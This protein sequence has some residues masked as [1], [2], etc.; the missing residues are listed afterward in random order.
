MPLDTYRGIQGE[1]ASVRPSSHLLGVV[2]VQ[3]PAACEPTQYSPAYTRLHLLDMRLRE[4]RFA[5]PNSLPALRPR[6]EHPVD[7]TGVEMQV[8]VERRAETMHEA[9]R[10]QSCLLGTV[11]VTVQSPSSN[12]LSRNGRGSGRGVKKGG[13]TERLPVRGMCAQRL[14]DVPQEDVQHGRDRSAVL[15]QKVPQA[16]GQRQHPMA[17]RKRRKD[18]IDQMR[19]ALRHAPSVAGETH[20]TPLAR[21]SQTAHLVVSGANWIALLHIQYI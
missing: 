17:H 1:A 8:L 16:L 4:E 18:M 9:H 11:R 2:L 13:G 6:L 7:H 19:S 20:T 10:P 3:V 15:V 12:P 14:L 5:K 21:E